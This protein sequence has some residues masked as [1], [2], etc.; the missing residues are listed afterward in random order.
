MTD[1][2]RLSTVRRMKDEDGIFTTPN[3][4]DWLA[5]MGIHNKASPAPALRAK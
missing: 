4:G 3:T 2:V 5:N 1:L